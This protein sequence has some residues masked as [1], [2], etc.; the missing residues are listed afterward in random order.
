MNDCLWVFI[1]SILISLFFDLP[2]FTWAWHLN[3]LLPG[4]H[5]IAKSIMSVLML[6]ILHIECL[7][8]NLIGS[9]SD[10]P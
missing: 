2:V 9:V 5:L 7:L 3:D 1:V 4:Q 10:S 8:P 6:T